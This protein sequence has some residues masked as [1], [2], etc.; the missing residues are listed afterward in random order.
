MQI[1]MRFQLFWVRSFD[2][3][4]R[5]DSGYHSLVFSFLYQPF[6]VGFRLVA[7][8]AANLKTEGARHTYRSITIHWFISH[9]P[10][11]I[12]KRVAL[13]YMQAPSAPVTRR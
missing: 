9:S 6:E 7:F 2:I 3:K 8:I 1:N 10:C 13:A 11:R 4:A 5:Y 12:D